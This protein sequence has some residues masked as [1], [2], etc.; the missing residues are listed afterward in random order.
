MPCCQF[1]NSLIEDEFERGYFSGRSAHITI[2]P[3]SV[4]IFRIK[5]IILI[6]QHHGLYEYIVYQT[7]HERE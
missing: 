6:I 1:A 5:I 7:I 2:A 3:K 4:C